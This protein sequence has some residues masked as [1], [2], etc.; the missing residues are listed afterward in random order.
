LK[1]KDRDWDLVHLVHVKGAYSVTRAAWSYMRDQGFGRIIMITSAS[2]IYGSFG[3]ANYSAAKLA[4][5]GLTHTLAR[6]GEKRNV[7]CNA[8]APIAASRMTE[9]V[10]TE[11]L[12]QAL[13]PE[14]VSPLILYLSHETCTENGSTFE[15]GGGWV[16]KL[17]WERTKGVSFPLN[18]PIT[19]EDIKDNY[20]AITD[21]TNSTH[22][23]SSQDSF[24]IIMENF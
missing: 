7:F 4:V 3:Q 5:V 17:R 13:K 19:V 16:S 8:V 24:A 18:K 12:M 6:E 23:K 1:M 10:F 14:Y 9:T 2:G 20:A 21:F 11:Q 22:P 15:I